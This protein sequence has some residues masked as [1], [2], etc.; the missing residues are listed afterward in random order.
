MG[1]VGHVFVVL[2][3]YFVWYWR[4]GG[5]T[6][7]MQTW[8]IRLTTPSGA[9]RLPWHAW[10]CAMSLAW[11][12]VIYFGAGLILG[13]FDRDRQFLHDRLAGTRLVFKQSTPNAPRSAS[14]NPPEHACGGHQEKHAGR[15]RRKERCPTVDD[16]E[17]GKQSIQHVEADSE[18]DAGKNPDADRTHSILHVG[19]RQG[20]RQHHQRCQRIDQLLPH[21]NV[22]AIGF[23]LVPAQVPDKQGRD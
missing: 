6:L 10:R 8:K 19:E 22:V 3:A 18:H 9:C 11:P 12:S 4:H 7:A 21:G 17:A 15:D 14:L 1:V 5:Q 2:G 20:Q 13:L 16:A 23:L